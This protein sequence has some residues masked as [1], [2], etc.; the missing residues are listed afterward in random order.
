MYKY[1]DVM[2]HPIVG[3][4]YDEINEELIFRGQPS[5]DL[6]GNSIQRLSRVCDEM[7]LWPGDEIT[8]IFVCGTNGKGTTCRALSHL[9]AIKKKRNCVFTSPEIFNAAEMI[10]CDGNRIKPDYLSKNLKKILRKYPQEIF[11]SFELMFL[12]Y[13]KVAKEAGSEYMIIEVGLG[14]SYD[15]TNILR[16]RNAVICTSISIDHTDVFGETLDSIAEGEASLFRAEDN[17]YLGD[18]P[19]HLRDILIRPIK[20]GRVSSKTPLNEWLKLRS[21]P[22]R[23]TAS[24]KEDHSYLLKPRNDEVA[25]YL[26]IAKTV[27]E[28]LNLAIGGVDVI[29]ESE[30]VKIYGRYQIAARDPIV[31]LDTAHNRAAVENLVSHHNRYNIDWIPVLS[32][33]STRHPDEL[34]EPLFDQVETVCFIK[35]STS[36]C[37]RAEEVAALYHDRFTDIQIASNLWELG[38]S[39]KRIVIFGSFPGTREFFDT[40]GLSAL[41]GGHEYGR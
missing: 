35:A 25:Y 31:I 18:V 26:E 16:K 17:L 29:K 28:E 11:T 37:H 1:E 36:R 39:D 14:G 20:T 9:L 10:E 34:L 33:R 23:S 27:L 7:E 3:Y 24:V 41:D 38:E 19:S 30:K 15:A 2:R 22:T 32:I 4:Q 5:S 13:L 40:S 8:V 12:S 21:L 6:T